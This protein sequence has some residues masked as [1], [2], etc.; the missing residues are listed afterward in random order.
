[1]DIALRA[2]LSCDLETLLALS[3]SHEREIGATTRAAFEELVGMSFR[4]RMTKTGD[5]FLVALAD[6]APAIAPN[7]RWFAARLERFVYVDRVV[8]ALAARHRGLGRLLYGDLVAAAAQS[9][10]ER[11]CCEVNI[12]PPNPASDAFHAALG[13]TEIG[14]AFL[15]DRGKTVRYLTLELAAAARNRALRFP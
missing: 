7:Y 11:I 6:R 8:V 1:M 4:A 15:P 9:G 2:P 12:V 14:R 3:N 5:A 10:F 13:F